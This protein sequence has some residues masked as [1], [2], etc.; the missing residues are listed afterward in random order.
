MTATAADDIFA[1]SPPTTP[2][3]NS[4]DRI[5]VTGD[6]NVGFTFRVPAA[7]TARTLR[8]YEI[9]AS[10]WS[11]SLAITITARLRD[12]GTVHTASASG[13]AALT[14]IYSCVF[15]SAIAGDELIVE[16]KVVDTG[17]GGP[18]CRC[19]FSGITLGVA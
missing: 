13:L 3:L 4:T 19:K 9:G 2:A 14:R 18:G 15:S 10:S 17:G 11:G 8:I 1:T 5:G 12:A 7:Q 6:N 16:F